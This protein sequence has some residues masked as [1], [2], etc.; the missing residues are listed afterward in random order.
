MTLK[1][2]GNVFDASVYE[3]MGPGASGYMGRE[4]GR[5]YWFNTKQ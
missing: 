3:L 5:W 2:A 1:L 4:S